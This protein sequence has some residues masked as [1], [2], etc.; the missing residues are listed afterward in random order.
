MILVFGSIVLVVGPVGWWFVAI[1]RPEN[2]TTYKAV[3]QQLKEARRY[4]LYIEPRK[5]KE[6]YRQGLLTGLIVGFVS[7][8]GACMWFGG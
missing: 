2:V 1:E 7:T 3:T 4:I 6:G 8:F 5:Y